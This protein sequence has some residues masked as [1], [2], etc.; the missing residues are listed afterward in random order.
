[1]VSPAAA[2]TCCRIPPARLCFPA[3]SMSRM[4]EGNCALFEQLLHGGSEWRFLSRQ[5]SK[6]RG[7]ELVPPLVPLHTRAMPG[8]G[9]EDRRLGEQR[10]GLLDLNPS[11]ALLFWFRIAL[12]LGKT[13]LVWRAEAADP[14][15]GCKRLFTPDCLTARVYPLCRSPLLRRE[16]HASGYP[17]VSSGLPSLSC[18]K[19][20]E[21]W[22][23]CALWP[24]NN[25]FSLRDLKVTLTCH[26]RGLESGGSHT[27]QIA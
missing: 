21:L 1:M 23:S 18:C 2:P 22:W 17:A 26:C 8:V 9:S 24:S 16:L 15:L 12:W 10:G 7:R 11:G 13:S 3:A 19:H 14:W 5:S 25:L 27:P 6:S 4:H 20:L